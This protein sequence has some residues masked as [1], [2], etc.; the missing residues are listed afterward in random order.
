M[1]R[2]SQDRGN[3]RAVPSSNSYSS[4]NNG[5]RTSEDNVRVDPEHGMDGRTFVMHMNKRHSDSLGGLPRLW[6]TCDPYV[7][8]CWRA[9]HTQLHRWRLDLSH[10]HED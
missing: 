8:A 7:T 2:L 5:V 4:S 3:R 9:F 6:E 10:V 1:V